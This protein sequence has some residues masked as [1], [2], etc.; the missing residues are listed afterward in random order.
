MQVIMSILYRITLF[1]S[2]CLTLIFFNHSVFALNETHY[3]KNNRSLA[4]SQDMPLNR[5]AKHDWEVGVKLYASGDYI[6]A[7]KFFKYSAELGNALSQY[8]L[9]VCYLKGQGTKQDYLKAKYWYERASNQGIAFSQHD[10][11]FMY[12]YGLGLTR[13]YSKASHYFELAAKQGDADAQMF[14]GINHSGGNGTDFN[15]ILAYAWLFCA[16]NNGN[17][18]SGLSPQEKIMTEKYINRI[19]SSLDSDQEL[20]ALKTAA[21]YKKLYVDPYIRS[22]YIN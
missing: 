5:I 6:N 11:G 2:L 7:A 9:A 22:V 13:D 15:L 1:F 20:C 16:L 19:Y 10:L 14:L 4:V 3:A 8:R 12:E 17:A 21:K 18:L